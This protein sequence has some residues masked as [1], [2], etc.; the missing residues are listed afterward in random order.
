MLARLPYAPSH[1]AHYLYMVCFQITDHDANAMFHDFV[2]IS[3][4]NYAKVKE[5][6]S[7]KVPRF[8]C[9]APN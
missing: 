2:A 6:A 5:L 1:I 9:L 7:K 4:C 8:E 3:M